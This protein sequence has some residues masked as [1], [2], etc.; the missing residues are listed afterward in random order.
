MANKP[1]KKPSKAI[2]A[3]KN[4]GPSIGFIMSGLS[5]GI[6]V[7]WIIMSQTTP[8]REELRDT[9]KKCSEISTVNDNLAKE[10][11]NLKNLINYKEIENNKIKSQL[12]EVKFDID[13]NVKVKTEIK[14]KLDNKEKEIIKLTVELNMLRSKNKELSDNLNNK[15]NEIDKLKSQQ[16]NYKDNLMASQPYCNYG[17]SVASGV[18]GVPGYYGQYNNACINVAKG[19]TAIMA[20][21]WFNEEIH[22]NLININDNKVYAVFSVP[23]HQSFKID[24]KRVGD[25]FILRGSKTYE[26]EITW[27]DFTTSVSF[28]ITLK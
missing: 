5:V 25:K 1:P 16:Y 4:I 7:T 2:K 15:Q 6:A 9:K 17:T 23:G 8:L 21:E 22:I 19:T 27:I 18:T 11:I 20:R 26:I 13:K 3:R 10:N 28:L 24:G 14:D 12:S